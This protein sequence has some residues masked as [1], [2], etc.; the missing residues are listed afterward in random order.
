[1]LIGWTWLC[2]WCG[3]RC[4]SEV[5]ASQG[6][7]QTYVED[8]QVCCRPNVLHVTVDADDG[9]ADGFAEAEST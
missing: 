4:D 5:D 2:A 1:M 8:C 7:S 3:Q 6:R 9:S